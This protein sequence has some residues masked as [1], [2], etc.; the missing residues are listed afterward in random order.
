MSIER[1]AGYFNS[2]AT[3][4][5]VSFSIQQ[6]RVFNF[7]NTGKT[8]GAATVHVLYNLDCPASNDNAI[9]K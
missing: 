2:F 6:N 3:I 1:L 4:G 9:T 8:N 5:H 7:L